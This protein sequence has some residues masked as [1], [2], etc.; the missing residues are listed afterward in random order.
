[1]TIKIDVYLNR[2]REELKKNEMKM[3]ESWLFMEID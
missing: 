3:E 2:K 1:M